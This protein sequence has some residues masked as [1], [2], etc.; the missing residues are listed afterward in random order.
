[1]E[2]NYAEERDTLATL[3][4]SA[5]QMLADNNISLD[6]NPALKEWQ[7]LMEKETKRKEKEKK[8][9]E[10]EKKE[11]EERRKVL[12]EKSYKDLTIEELRF[13]NET[14]E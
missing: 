14:D 6:T 10:K 8:R 3:L 4:T 1:M 2:R 12:I 7:E 11:A 9:Q 5:C 13:L